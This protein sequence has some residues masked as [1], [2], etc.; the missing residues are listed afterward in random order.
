MCVKPAAILVS[1]DPAFIAG[2]KLLTAMVNQAW[3]RRPQ[4]SYSV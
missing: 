3:K 1:P 4:S 2:K